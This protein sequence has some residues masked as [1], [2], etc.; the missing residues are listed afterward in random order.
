MD[1]GTDMTLFDTIEALYLNLDGNTPQI[2]INNGSDR[3]LSDMINNQAKAFVPHTIWDLTTNDLSVV[4]SYNAH[5][6]IKQN[7]EGLLWLITIQM[8]LLWIMSYQHH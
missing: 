8:L 2:Y 7:N 3:Y 4:D 5:V 1:P 6:L